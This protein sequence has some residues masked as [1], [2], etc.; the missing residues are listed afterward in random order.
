MNIAQTLVNHS[1]F[2]APIVRLHMFFC[3]AFGYTNS[4]KSPI[5]KSRTYFYRDGSAV[6]LFPSGVHFVATF[7]EKE[8][9]N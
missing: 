7:T 1:P 4:Y 8:L 6:T 9:L 3:N 5:T 2:P